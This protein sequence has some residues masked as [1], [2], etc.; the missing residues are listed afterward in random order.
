MIDKVSFG[1]GFARYETGG[2]NCEP[3]HHHH[4]AFCNRCGSVFSFEGDLLDT[5]EQALLDRTGFL[6]A[7][8]EV[9]LFGYCRECREAMEEGQNGK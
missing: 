3:G 2:L 9:K 7:D 8:H 6:V 1:D 4:H 5:L